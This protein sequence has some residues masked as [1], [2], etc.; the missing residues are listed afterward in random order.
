[1]DYCVLKPFM[2]L[3]SANVNACWSEASATAMM[4]G[5]ARVLISPVSTTLS[6]SISCQTRNS[7]QRVSADVS[8]PWTLVSK[9][10]AG[11]S[12]LAISSAR[13]KGGLVPKAR[14]PGPDISASPPEGYGS[15]A[16]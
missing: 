12:P 14:T 16:A 11:A 2:R 4:P 9:I 6:W 1:M 3:P 13:Y 15:S 8:P 5:W 10:D 7:P